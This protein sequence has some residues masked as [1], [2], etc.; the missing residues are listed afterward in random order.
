MI[1]THCHIL[2]GVD[3]ASAIRSHSL[4]MVRIAIDDGIETIVATSHIKYPIYPNT[5]EVLNTALYE[6][7]DAMDEE[8][9]ELNIVIGAENFVNHRTI[10]LLDENKFV[11]Y[12][13][14]GKYM[15]VEF[16]WTK[17]IFDDPTRYLKKIL[18]QGIIP[19]VA[20]PER[21]EW[22]HEDIEIVR[23]WRDMGC[24]MQVN[25]TSVLG[26]DKMKQANIFAKKLLEEDLVDI[27]ASDAHRPFASR[28]PKLKDAYRFIEKH[29]GKKRADLYFIEN[30]KKL[31]S[32]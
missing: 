1:D 7:L 13:D 27:V 2:W 10:A 9:L 20:H 31:I 32:E 24:L 11:T 23:S 22:V 26:L 4:D 6:L 16:S 29:Y 12:N 25:R 21:Y 18:Q 3:D 14:A 19:V 28:Y 15:L 30:P 8:G 17:N 5:I